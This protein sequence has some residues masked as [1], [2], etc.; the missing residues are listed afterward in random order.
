MELERLAALLSILRAH[1]VRIYHDD[2]V[3]LEL[4]P[5]STPESTRSTAAES[6]T[7]AC[8]HGHYAHVNGLCT[9]GCSVEV[10]APEEKP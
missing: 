6:D 7:C 8:G 5:Q 10:C 1:G 9:M 4:D 2:E 3:R